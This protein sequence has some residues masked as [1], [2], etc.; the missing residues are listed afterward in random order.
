VTADPPTARTCA[1]CGTGLDGRRPHARFCGS[2]CR[3]EAARL[4]A[5]LAGV[6]VNEHHSVASYLARPRKRA[7]RTR[8]LP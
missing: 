3:R 6:P 8:G 4:R 5:L 7:N 1:V 2:G